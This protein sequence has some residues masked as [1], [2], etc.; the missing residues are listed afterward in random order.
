MPNPAFIQEKEAA[1]REIFQKLAA[2]AVYL[3]GS[4]ARE[5]TGPLSDLDFGL[6]L[7][8]PHTPASYHERRLE[9][10]TAL[11]RLFQ[12]G[13]VDVV[14]LNTAPPLLRLRVI[15]GGALILDSDPKKRVTFEAR[16]IQAFCDTQPLRRAYDQALLD[17]IRRGRFYG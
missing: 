1:L 16:T 17:A 12:A 15:E 2:A 11:M 8:P 7:G 5:T 9:A 13:R 10:T 3:F 4:A 14:I 6:L